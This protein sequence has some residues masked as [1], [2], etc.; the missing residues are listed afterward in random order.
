MKPLKD[1]LKD[2]QCRLATDP[3]TKFQRY[4]SAV[5]IDRVGQ[6][7][8]KYQPKTKSKTRRAQNAPQKRAVRKGFRE[9]AMKRARGRHARRGGR[10]RRRRRKVEP[11]GSR[12]TCAPGREA[13]LRRTGPRGAK[14]SPFRDCLS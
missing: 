7:K 12:S 2:F 8:P 1:F 13:Q 10:V 3:C 4:N 6:G 11:R 9:E 5:G 14:L